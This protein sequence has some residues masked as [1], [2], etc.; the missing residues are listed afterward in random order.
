MPE[1]WTVS[2]EFK[3]H[4][5]VKLLRQALA[6]VA[7]EN[8]VLGVRTRKDTL[9]YRLRHYGAHWQHCPQAMCKQSA[10]VWSDAK[11]FETL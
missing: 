10:S 8:H 3:L 6:Q 4:Q 1:M 7:K 9:D 5:A 2:K 11:I